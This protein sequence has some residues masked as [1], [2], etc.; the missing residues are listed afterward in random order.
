MA[1]ER[2]ELEQR[3]G[4]LT[5]SLPGLKHD[6]PE[7]MVRLGEAVATA[8]DHAGLFMVPLHRPQAKSAATKAD[9][10]PARRPGR[11]RVGP[12]K[13]HKSGLHRYCLA[14]A[15]ETEHVL[16]ARDGRASIPSIRWPAPE[17]ASGTTICLE[18]GQWRALSS[19][20]TPSAWSE[21]PRTP[22]A[23]RRL[24]ETVATADAADDALSET[25]AENEGMPP[26]REPRLRRGSTRLRR[27]RAVALQ[28][29]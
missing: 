16:S 27:L 26:K 3:R 19:R 24:A 9:K 6:Q 20:P 8:Y 12:T 2:S 21:W 1:S 7:D 28:P 14:C 25:A 17:P 10:T 18:C 13:R 11:G 4:Q 23:T 22:V 5:I 15:R 29:R